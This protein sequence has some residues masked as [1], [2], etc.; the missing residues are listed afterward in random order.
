VARVVVVGGGITGLS[1]A[2]QLASAGDVEVVVREASDRLGGNIGTSAFAGRP[3]IDEAADAFLARV[4]HGTA[5]ART[6]GFGET[7]ASPATGR[8]A[9]WRGRLHPIPEGIVLGVP[10]DAA[11]LATSSLL[12]WRGKARAGLDL[13]LPRRDPHDSIGDLV[14]HRF[15]GE[16]HDR[17]VD[18]LVGSIYAADT[19]RFSLAMVPQVASLAGGR[20][21]LLLA[22]R[23]ARR[24]TPPDPDGVVFRAPVRGMADLVEATAAAA[25]SAGAR[26]ETGA[27]VREVA[28][29][30]TRWRVDGLDASA[31]V[32]AAPARQAA[33]MV[34]GIP[35]LAALLG[36]IDTAGVAII[37]MAIP[38]GDWPAR[39]HGYSGYLVPKSVQRRVTA[40][41]FGSQK[42]DHWRDGATE[43]L[44]VSIGRDGAPFTDLDDDDLVSRAVDEVSAHLGV[45][46]QPSLTR[47]SRWP[48]AFPQYR[49]GHQDWLAAVDRA[50]PAG[51]VLAGASYRGIGI[52]ACIEQ[53]MQAAVLAMEVL[54]RVR[55]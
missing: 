6:V 54:A 13:V 32:L 16:V 44:R 26:I 47:V 19:D 43:V 25:R 4:P 33:P 12:S 18:A 53:G 38:S 40:V 17:L 20:R 11:A 10:G 42:W 30:G 1:A 15:G 9:V 23:G 8:A 45:S 35:D 49:P 41:S 37:T 31:I 5:L 39:L 52:P 55:Q 2:L 14:R 24:R 3:A 51:L 46:L 29:D 27:A 21:S 22:A 36:R 28:V 50:S 48:R 34:S 7:L